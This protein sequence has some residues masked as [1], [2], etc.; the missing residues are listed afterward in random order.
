M[1]MRRENPLE[2]VPDGGVVAPRV[3]VLCD[4]E[5]VHQG[6]DRMLST[7]TNLAVV[8]DVA[9][10]SAPPDVDVLIVTPDVA[11]ALEW[12]RSRSRN[13]TGPRTLVLIRG[14]DGRALEEAAAIS[15]DGYVLE[16]ELTPHSL[17]RMVEEVVRGDVP[18]PHELTNYL[19]EK[20]RS[21]QS[22]PLSA[23]FLTPRESEVLTLLCEGLSNK[24]IARRLR[25]SQNGVKRHVGNVLSKLN[26]PNRA[27]AVA[28]AIRE[29]LT[30]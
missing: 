21:K 29:G 18:V 7:L 22:E 4:S 6:L 10:D 30:D 28:R 15:A 24:Q 3:A 19:L 23:R 2:S 25:I 20:A 26:C 11:A 14:S 17:G 9:V 8:R 16:A 12:R 1:L 27:L 13:A 5:L